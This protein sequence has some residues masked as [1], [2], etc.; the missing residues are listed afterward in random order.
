MTDRHPLVDAN[1]DL[2]GMAGFMLDVN[3]LLASELV[4]LGKPDECWAA[5]MLWCRAWQQH[6]PASL[7]NDER[8]L[9]AFSGAGSRWPKV[10]QMAMRGFVL[11]SD[12]RWYHPVLVEEVNN[13]WKKREAYRADQERLK[14]W[15]QT[16]REKREGDGDGNRA[17]NPSET[18]LKCVSP[19]VSPAVSSGVSEPVDRDSTGTGTGTLLH[20]S[21]LRSDGGKPP[22]PKTATD[23]NDPKTILWREGR[24]ILSSLTRKPVKEVGSLIG[25]L[26]DDAKS[27][28]GTV[29]HAMVLDIVR[30]AD[31]QRP[32][33]PF[34]WIRAAI[35][36]RLTPTLFAN[37]GGPLDPYGIKAW[38]ARRSDVKPATDDRTK[39]KM[40]A[41][42]GY[43]PEVW[44]EMIADAAGLPETW[45]GNWDALG[46][47][48]NADVGLTPAV[49]SA[50][51]DQ[52]RRMR[53]QGQTIG[54]I[55]VFDAVV[56]AAYGRTAA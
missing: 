39:Q 15:R 4:A 40:P 9:A 52:A 53:G 20:T 54:S 44:A 5:M 49:L 22:K 37:S 25:T 45:R 55:K 2:R 29:D 17:S 13:A 32:D 33:N 26:V 21:S 23:P 27:P 35:K 1:V 38:T 7:P 24:D 50:I 46:D 12:N 34:P 41:I 31:A 43:F 3:R 28:G 56:Q 51:S 19:N 30:Q 47:W 18:D 36:A 8:V 48:M 14:N 6:P 11:C 42:N 16:Q 10:K